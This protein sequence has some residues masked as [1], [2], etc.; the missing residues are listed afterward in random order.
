VDR[1]LR[2]GE[3][4]VAMQSEAQPLRILFSMRHLGSFRMYESV[5]RALASRGHE[6]HIVVDRAERLGWRRGLDQLLADHP[7]VRWSWSVRHRRRLFWFEFSRVV[8]IWLDYLRYFDPS[9]DSTPILRKRA[10]DL[11]PKPLVRATDA[12]P[13]GSNAGREMLRRLLRLAERALPRVREIDESLAQERPDVML[14]TPLIYLGS[15][16]VEMLRSA[17]ALGIR[18]ALCVGSWDHLSSKAFIR[19]VPQRILVWNDTQRAEAVDLHRVPAERVVVTGA[20]CYDQWF[21]RQASRP[22]ERFCRDVHL[23]PDRP[24]LLYVCSALFWGSPVEAEYVVSWI[25]SLRRSES[26]ALRS[27]GILIRPHPAR[28]KEWEAIDLTRFDNV[29]L[30]GSSP[31][32]HDSR[33]DYFD[34]LFH[35]R[36]VVGLN[37]SA[38]LEAAIVGRPVHALLPAEFHDNQEGTLHF[39]Y[40]MTVGG[41]LLRA[42]RD[43]DTHHAQL[44]ESLAHGADNRRFVEAFIRPL[45]LE[46]PATETF[47]DA[48]EALGHEP[49]PAPE[50]ASLAL[51]LLRVPFLPF[52][53]AARLAFA[54]S[55]AAIDK[56]SREIARERKHRQERVMRARR[57]RTRQ[58]LEALRQRQKQEILQQRL[59][60]REKQQGAREHRVAERRRQKAEVQKQHALAKQ[61]RQRRKKREAFR[62]RILQKLGLA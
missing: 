6:V 61:A 46:R 23:R 25:E 15:P 49:Q 44:L 2:R 22:Y 52:A 41:G 60:K 16:Q 5:V 62:Q 20:Q 47:A 1:R 35:S 7:N 56:T 39:H 36:A 58:Q 48:V 51:V 54:R 13:L 32:D 42:A 30:Y 43:F 3:Y 34:S 59:A 19:E 26:D 38:F 8:R 21:G 45:G 18:T 4:S 17:K 50:R 27:I 28:T 12:W 53:Y 10:A 14:L 57:L 55:A 37:T 31:I 24:F 9:Y 33:N 11:V 40:L 29:T